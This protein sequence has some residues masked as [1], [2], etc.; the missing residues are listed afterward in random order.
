MWTPFEKA[1]K[2]P[3][4]RQCAINAACAQCVCWSDREDTIQS[5]RW[6]I[7]NC[8]IT[9][10]ALWHLRPYQHRKGDPT[11]EMYARTAHDQNSGD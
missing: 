8:A 4:S 6:L 3:K 10:C 2:N 5:P 1:R 7:G 11:P 9:D